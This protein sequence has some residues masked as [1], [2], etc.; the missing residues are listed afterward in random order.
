MGYSME[1]RS[2]ESW[3]KT[4]VPFD[5]FYSVEF[6]VPEDSCL[7]QFKVWNMTPESI[8]VLVKENSKIL[9]SLKVGDIMNLKYYTTDKHNPIKQLNTEIRYIRKEDNGRLQ[10]HFLIGLAILES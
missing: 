1:N 7:H 8:C 10:G 9:G 3:F 5:Q 6:S 4:V 2:Q